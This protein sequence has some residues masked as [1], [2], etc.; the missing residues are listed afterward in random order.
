MVE[1]GAEVVSVTSRYNTDSTHS[2]TSDVV[3]GHKYYLRFLAKKT[4][5]THRTLR[6]GWSANSSNIFNLNAIVIVGENLPESD[7][8]F[9][10]T[11][12][13]VVGANHLNKVVFSGYSGQFAHADVWDVQIIDLTATFGAGNEPSKEFMDSII[14]EHGYFDEL[15]INRNDLQDKEIK[16]MKQA[17]IQLGGSL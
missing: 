1:S 6:F 5:E 4:G 2:V 15:I 13:G 10:Y 3:N 17:L 12:V 11:F 7:V 8:A 9:S 14:Q 16:A